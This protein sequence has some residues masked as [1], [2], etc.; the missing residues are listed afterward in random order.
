MSKKTIPDLSC[1]L[2]EFHENG[3]TVFEQM[4]DDAQMQCWRDVL[5]G[6][7]REFATDKD[8]PFWFGNMA[9]RAP[10]SMMPALANPTVLDFAEQVMGPFV[11]LDN[12]TLVGFPSVDPESAKGKVSHWHRDRWAHLPL[13]VYERP[14]AVN[15][16]TY[17][18]DLDEKSGPLRVIPGSHRRAVSLE[19]EE[20][21]K[22]HPDEQLV[23]AKAGDIVFIHNMILHS[24]TPN[25]SGKTRYFFSLYYNQSWM[26][27]TDNH[28][29]PNT[30]QLIAEARRKGDRRLLR[31]FGVDDNLE[32][33]GNAGFVQPDEDLWQKWIA[34]DRAALENGTP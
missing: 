20:L 4:Y 13:G 3:F 24:G 28:S 27:T 31:L 33:R 11:Q 16:I 14:L 29:G 32:T 30:Q 5:A 7:Q 19:P 18:Q 2:E 10:R 23:C 1:R 17:F 15:A 9:E 25:T 21:R 12:L 26:K 6:L 34:E 8:A 22:P